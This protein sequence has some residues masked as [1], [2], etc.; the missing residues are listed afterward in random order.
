ML[1]AL[2]GCSSKTLLQESH[3]VEKQED[4]NKQQ[5]NTHYHNVRFEYVI[6]PH[7]RVQI[8]I[9]NHPELSTKS[10][11]GMNS[12]A[13]I[14]VDHAGLVHLP[15]IGS[16]RLGGL[17]QPRAARKIQALYGK[18]LKKSSV[19]LE[20]LNKKAYVIGEVKT[21]GVV[22]LPNEQ[23]TLLEAIASVRG[24]SNYA[25]KEKI[26]IMRKSGRGTKVEVV[27][28]TDVHSLSY[29]TMMIRPNDIVY[30]TSTKMK[31]VVITAMPLF[32]LASDALLPFIRYQDLT[33]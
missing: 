16:V 19:H 2:M 12:S 27:D 22:K 13:G 20:V 30:V 8:T 4:R 25:N 21:P 33:N 7:D 18:Y 15:L 32:R 31:D 28:L 17:T 23:T 11:A 9:Y 26:V 29:A 5:K 3:T 1:F 14:L 6:A 24:F 10:E